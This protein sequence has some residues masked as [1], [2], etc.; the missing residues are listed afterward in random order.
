MSVEVSQIAE[1]VGLVLLGGFADALLIRLDSQLLFPFVLIDVG[2][3]FVVIIQPRL[4]L[5]IFQGIFI[6]PHVLV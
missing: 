5:K 1:P 3:I 2:H 6:V 4:H